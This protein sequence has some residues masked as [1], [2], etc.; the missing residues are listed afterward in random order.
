MTTAFDHLF[1]FALEHP[2]AVTPDMLARIA[3]ILA[4]RCAGVKADASELAALKQQRQALPQPKRGGGVALIPL[5]G[6]VAPRMNLMSEM[7]GGATFQGLEQ[8]VRAAIANPDVQTLVFDVDSPGGNVAGASEFHKILLQARTE[9][10][11]IA[12]ASYLCASAAYWAMSA[13]T[14]I[15]A[16]PS[17]QIGGV[18]VLAIYDDLSA[19]FEQRGIKRDVLRA[20][21]FKGEA[22]GGP[23]SDDARAHIQGLIDTTYARMTLDIANGRGVKASVVRAG[24]GEGFC[25]L[26]E[27]ALADG[28][29]DEIGT[30]EETLT[31]LGVATAPASLSAATDQ[32]PLAATSQELAANALWR[33]AI[34]GEALTL[35]L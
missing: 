10:P 23:L 2:W 22:I 24:Y 11:C 5:Q 4:D 32:E 20:G 16:P 9:K 18:G 6:V 14:K 25:V 27:T 17:A 19:A 31:R 28:M 29:I 7:S 12:V 13:A 26:A 3:G 8:Q 33:N 15:I 35:D 21:K 34:L 1:A 30:L